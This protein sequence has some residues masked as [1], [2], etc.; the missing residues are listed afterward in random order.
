MR[1]TGYIGVD[2]DGTATLFK[3]APSLCVKAD[4]SAAWYTEDLRPSPFLILRTAQTNPSAFGGIEP[5]DMRE[6]GIDV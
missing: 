6:V 2:E 3:D 4:G 1:L 5:G